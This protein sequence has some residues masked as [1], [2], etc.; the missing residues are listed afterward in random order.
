[1][2]IRILFLL[3]PMLCYQGYTQE[4]SQWRG[5]NRDGIFPE[6]NLLK[7][8]PDGGPKLLW[9]YD[10]LGAGYS[11]PA[12]TSTRIYETGIVDSIGYVLCFDHSGKLL[13]RKPL[14]RDYT[15][16]WPGVYSTPVICGDLGYLVNGL[17]GLYCFS[18]VNGDV[19]WKR[20]IV[21]DYKG[22]KAP[23]GFLD[24]L[25]VDGEKLYCTPGGKGMNVVALNRRNGGLVWAS[26]GDTIV[27]AYCTPI[28]VE[29][30]GKKYFIYQTARLIIALETD[31]GKLAWKHKKRGRSMPNT[32]VYQNGY[33]FMPDFNKGSTKLKISKN[34]NEITEVWSTPDMQ[35][36]MGDA[37]LLGNR[38]YGKGKNNKFY[39]VDWNTGKE[40]YS[41]PDKNM[42]TTIISAENLLYCYCYNGTF[43]LVSPM[44]KGFEKAGSF[45]VK[46]GSENHCSHPVIKDGRL[47]I[48]HDNSL[49]VYNIMNAQP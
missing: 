26:G 27:D 40:L 49:F 41:E 8:W 35:T 29:N 10:K 37:V 46:G 42:V 20:N 39:C 23:S 17:G 1:M 34:W 45:Q 13:W 11:S 47:Y 19:V 3:L 12:V 15:G 18:A 44:D 32:P 28:L 6:T 30:D 48:R 5:P 25:I 22:Q 43:N 7:Q 33:L 9:K 4:I 16:E 36:N 38:I 2:K 14:G 21:N 31:N 24:N